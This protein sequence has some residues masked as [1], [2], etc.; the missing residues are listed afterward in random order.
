MDPKE[1]VALVTG[2]NRGIGRAIVHALAAAG[3]KRV[4]AASRGP[5]FAG[6]FPSNVTELR[7]D[8]TSDAQVAEAAAR[9][10]DV[11]VLVNNAG[12]LL[13]QSLLGASNLDSARSE[14]EVNYFG[15]LRMARAFAPV[16]KQNGGGAI[17][18][19]LSI[20]ARVNM[21][22]IGSYSASKA[23]AL[24]MTEGIRAELA[25]QGTKVIAVLPGVVDT[26]M[27]SRISVPKIAPEAVAD[28]LIA[29]LAA[30]TEEV[31]PGASDLAELLRS[32][33]KAVERQLAAM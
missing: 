2:A 21:P 3:A 11:N 14:L 7:L 25:S 8:V 32:D 29:A 23:A 27:A 17:V 24:S 28:A 6:A 31:Y 1:I 16:L 22:R 4:Y 10:S 9:S 30:G 5:G 19:V 13:G 33:R 26:D 20:L 12:V 18:N 15:P